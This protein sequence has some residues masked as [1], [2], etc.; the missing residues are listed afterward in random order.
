MKK[1]IKFLI[2]FSLSPLISADTYV[3][4]IESCYQSEYFL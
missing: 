2:L 3:T 4:F 1:L